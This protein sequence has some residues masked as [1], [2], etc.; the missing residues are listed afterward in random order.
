MKFELISERHPVFQNLKWSCAFPPSYSVH[1]FENKDNTSGIISL[2]DAF[3]GY[4]SWARY[5]GANPLIGKI[6]DSFDKEEMDFLRRKYPEFL[7][8]INNL[9]A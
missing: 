6:Y 1:V 7:S 5:T 9:D 8:A 3:G 4:V 2:S